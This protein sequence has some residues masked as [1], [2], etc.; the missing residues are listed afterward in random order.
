MK[1]K[2]KIIQIT[3]AGLL[4]LLG[5]KRYMWFKSTKRSNYQLTKKTI[6]NNSQSSSRAA[7]VW[8][9]AKSMKNTEIK[10]SDVRKAVNVQKGTLCQIVKCL[11]AY[12]CKELKALLP[13][14]KNAFLSAL[15]IVA[16]E[17]GVG[18]EYTTKYK[19]ED[20][21]RVRKPSMD[22][23]ERWLVKHQSDKDALIAAFLKAK[24]VPAESSKKKATKAA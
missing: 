6:T 17:M 23:V 22:L 21:V 24:A 5:E 2:A 11:Y 18:K 19:G 10:L 8:G 3:L 16:D 15:S 4:Y 7:L 12:D 14:N 20:V 13:K 9:S 1:L